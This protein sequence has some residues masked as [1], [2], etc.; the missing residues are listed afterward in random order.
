MGGSSFPSSSTSSRSRSRTF[1]SSYSTSYNIPR[2]SYSRRYSRETILSVL[3]HPDYCISGYSSVAVKKGVE[4]CEKQ[5]NKLSIEERDKFDEETLVNF[6]NIRKQSFTSHEEVSDG[7]SKKYIVVTIIVAAKGAHELPPV[8][9]SELL[10]TALQKLAS[11]PSN[12]IMLLATFLLLILLYYLTITPSNLSLHFS[13]A[14]ASASASASPSATG[15]SCVNRSL[16][17]ANNRH[18]LQARENET[19]ETGT[20]TSGVVQKARKPDDRQRAEPSTTNEGGSMQ[21]PHH[22]CH[23][24][25]FAKQAF[26]KC[27]GIDSTPKR[28]R[29]KDD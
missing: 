3:Q 12:N 5:F 7:V 25:G 8:K 16:L 29:E 2:S 11:I 23:F 26:L 4:E 10:K 28:R 19:R 6:N 21:Q 18:K 17:T 24:F 9:S 27:L 13:A 1:R 14:S 20:S 22:P 15:Q